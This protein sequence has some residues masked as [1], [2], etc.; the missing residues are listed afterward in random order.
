[1]PRKIGPAP[2]PPEVSHHSA[3]EGHHRV[4]AIEPPCGETVEDLPRLRPGLARLAGGND[5]LN[6]PEPS[7]TQ[8]SGYTT[9][10]QRPHV[11]ISDEGDCVRRRHVTN[12]GGHRLQ[13]PGPDQHVVGR[14]PC[15]YGKSDSPVHI[16]HPLRG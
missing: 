13:K 7:F 5:D 10:V 15:G 12:E 16:T 8:D 14:G 1:M 4:I 2:K 9:P 11:L 3:A 6:D